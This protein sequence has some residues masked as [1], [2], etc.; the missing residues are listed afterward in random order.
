[1]TLAILI[2]LYRLDA[3]DVPDPTYALNI[4]ECRETSL[5]A[6]QKFGLFQ[7]MHPI[8]TS[9][10]SIEDRLRQK[11]VVPSSALKCIREHIRDEATDIHATSLSF[12][13]EK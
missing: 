2:R 4:Y 12:I 7:L 8:V 1:M 5:H 10:S 11:I 6:G 9:C 3:Y 13:W